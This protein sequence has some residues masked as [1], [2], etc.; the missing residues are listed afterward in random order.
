MPSSGGVRPNPI[1]SELQPQESGLR[2]FLDEGV[3]IKLVDDPFVLAP[4]VTA[5]KRKVRRMTANARILVLSQLDLLLAVAV[6]ALAEEL[7][8]DVPGRVPVV[9]D[10]LVR[11][12]ERDLVLGEYVAHGRLGSLRRRGS[13]RSA[14]EPASPTFSTT[15]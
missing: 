8:Q 10:R 5:R 1:P 3:A 9:V 4:F 12:L 2:L 14:A 15:Q 13:I 6:T 11:R 7:E